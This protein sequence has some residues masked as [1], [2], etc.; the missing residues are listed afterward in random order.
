MHTERGESLVK[1]RKRKKKKGKE[2]G[3][4]GRKSDKGEEDFPVRIRHLAR[5]GQ[6]VNGSS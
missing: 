6:N 5:D 4:K 3:E 2:K 1:K